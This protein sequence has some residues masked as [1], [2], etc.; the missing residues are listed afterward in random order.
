MYEVVKHLLHQA[1][2][3]TRGPLDE[4]EFA[5]LVMEATAY[6]LGLFLNI[7]LLRSMKT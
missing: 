5:L 4:A 7:L 1:N 6:D 3:R 2:T